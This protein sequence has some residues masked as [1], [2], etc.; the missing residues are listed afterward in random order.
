MRFQVQNFGNFSSNSLRVIGVFCKFG[1]FH[2]VVVVMVVEV[3]VE[4][5]KGR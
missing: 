5:E 3:E 4:L 1:F 2:E